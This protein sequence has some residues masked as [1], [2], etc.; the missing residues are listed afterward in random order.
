MKYL[1]NF[2]YVYYLFYLEPYENDNKAI[3]IKGFLNYLKL[4]TLP[5]KVIEFIK[6]LAQVLI[7]TTGQTILT[8]H[9]CRS[10]SKST[11]NQNK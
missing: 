7:A 1:C 2:S 3:L 4:T 10:S 6:M 9:K 5:R 8:E 11:R